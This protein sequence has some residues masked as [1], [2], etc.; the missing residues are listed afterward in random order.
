MFFHTPEGPGLGWTESQERC[1]HL[2][3]GGDGDFV[4]CVERALIRG[5]R[6]KP[7]KGRPMQKADVD[8][9]PVGFGGGGEALQSLCGGIYGPT[10]DAVV[11]HVREYLD[12][13]RDAHLVVHTGK[14][15]QS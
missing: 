15:F 7:G 6:K 3:R 12:F 1:G 2:A 13:Q 10:L 9:R 11:P 4:E 14:V 5:K 8:I